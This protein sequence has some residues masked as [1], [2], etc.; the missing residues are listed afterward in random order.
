M[1][2]Y[3]CTSQILRRFGVLILLGLLAV[4]AAAPL[5]AQT[6]TV[7]HS[8]T[9][10]EGATPNDA[11]T[12]DAAG[13]LY[14]TTTFG[15][16]GNGT[17]FKLSHK[18]GSWILTVLYVFKGGNDGQSPYAGLTFG[19]DGSLYGTTSAGGG[20]TCQYNELFGNGCGTVF[21]LKPPPRTCPAPECPWIETVLHRFTGGSDGGHA[22]LGKL[23]FDQAGNMYGATAGD[24]GGDD[25]TV[26]ELSRSGGQW[27]YS[28]L[29][30]FTQDEEPFAGVALDHAGNLYGTT[31][32]GE[33]VFEL[34][35]SS[36]WAYQSLYNFSGGLDG[37]FPDGGVTFDAAGNM[38]GTT[39][40]GGG[41]GSGTVYK[42]TM[43]QGSWVYQHIASLP[44][45]AG[46]FD[47]PTLDAA[48]NMY[49]SVYEGNP[50]PGVIK[51]TP[52]GSVT[53]LHDFTGSS[54]FLPVGGVTL[55]ASG[56][57]YG[58]TSSGGGGA[59]DAGQGC[60]VIFEITP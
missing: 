1:T 42:L 4:A 8:F 25:G 28:I 19:P 17:V 44:S 13:N 53:D 45:Y 35:A 37:D 5:Q 60:G 50:N 54:G 7:L 15:E 52:L 51:I 33:N 40:D 56:N 23:A 47:A 3:P 59:C 18:N 57:I 9:G 38:L 43:S 34:V 36:G 26:Y 16:T 49:A 41:L 48:G 55:D 14:G 2:F 6:Y 29:H 21:N 30:H 31:V 27:S 12:M 32:N 20:G 46:P 58:T 24:A 10:E 11:L 22:N 39:F